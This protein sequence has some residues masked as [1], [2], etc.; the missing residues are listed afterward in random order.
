M[1]SG[2]SAFDVL[3]GVLARLEACRVPYDLKRV[4]DD[5]IMVLIATPGKRWEIEVMK[6]G[7]LEVE[8]FRTAG[9]RDDCS[10][11]DILDLCKSPGAT[12]TGKHRKA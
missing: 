8:E 6:D 12:R 3:R 10:L 9:L 2:E 11:T 1:T 7:S 5:A 4:R